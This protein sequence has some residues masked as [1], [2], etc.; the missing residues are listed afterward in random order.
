MAYLVKQSELEEAKQVQK[1]F[2]QMSTYVYVAII[3]GEDIYMY[4]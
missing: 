2:Q 3:S 4:L 1:H